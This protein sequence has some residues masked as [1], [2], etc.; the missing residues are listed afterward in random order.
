MTKDQ[1]TVVPARLDVWPAWEAA[2]RSVE[3]RAPAAAPFGGFDW[4]SAWVDAYR[5]R[6]LRGVCVGDSA[7]PHALG[8]IEAASG[9]RWRFAGA[10]VTAQRGL[11]TPAGGEE[12]AWS[13]FG[14]WLRA[15]GRRWSTL[16]GE[17]LTDTTV[18]ALPHARATPVPML[19][20]DLPSDF[21]AYLKQRSHGTAKR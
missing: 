4:L 21:D 1:V 15:H 14:D 17:G 2:W 11:I 19:A 8:L 10:P 13:V 9:G 5:P 6:A 7:E 3:R 16:E 20:L 18:A 12:R